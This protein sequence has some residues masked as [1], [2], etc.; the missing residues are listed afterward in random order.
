MSDPN[1]KAEK[2]EAQRAKAQQYQEDIRGI[3]M[4]EWGKIS[5]LNREVCITEKI[6]G[7]NAAIGIQPVLN[8]SGRL[9]EVEVDGSWY[10]VYAQ[11]RNRVLTPGNDNFGFAAWV[12]RHREA[13]V[14]NLGIGLHFGEWWGVGIGR[15]YGLSERRFSLFNVAKWERKPE[16]ALALANLRLAGAAVYTVPILYWGPWTNVLGYHNPA[17]STEAGQTVWLKPEDMEGWEGVQDQPNPRPR[18]APNFELEWLKRVG[19][20]AA[21]GFM[22]PEGV[23]VFHQASGTLFKATCE[24]DAEYKGNNR[25]QDE[26][27]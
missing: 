7:T 9:L 26:N 2:A 18:F 23:V 10:T 20:Q 5:R 17:A 19:S 12:Q 4:V 1:R 21:P 8:P 16:G 24:N 3:V 14:R 11:S 27:P 13:L 22:N 6:D 25:T 15:G